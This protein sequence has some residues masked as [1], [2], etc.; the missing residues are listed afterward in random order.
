MSPLLREIV[1]NKDYTIIFS[2]F[3]L[4]IFPL[5][6]F[7]IIIIMSCRQHGYLWPSLAISP[8]HSSPPAGL[9]GYILCPHIAAVC[10]FGLVVLLLL[11]HMW[12]SIGVR[13]LRA[14]PCFSSSV[15]RPNYQHFIPNLSTLYEKN[16]FRH[17]RNA[18]S[19]SQYFFKFSLF[20]LLYDRVHLMIELTLPNPSAQD[21]CNTR[22]ISKQSFTGL[23]SESSSSEILP[24]CL[25]L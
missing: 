11:G 3:F 24:S 10:K 1:Q 7:I 22:S 25:R 23:N 14:R 2:G 20:S 18:I 13:H 4:H 17:Y 6:T 5:W 12:G 9:L 15:R 19:F 21:G 16:I 8:Y